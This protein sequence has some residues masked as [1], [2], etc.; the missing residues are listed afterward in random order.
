MS[1]AGKS[2]I[3]QFDST[4]AGHID[5]ENVGYASERPLGREVGIH[6]FR[7]REQGMDGGPPPA[8]TVEG[9]A[10][11]PLVLNVGVIAPGTGFPA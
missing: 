10:L 11:R 8:M 5:L 6:A 3:T 4:Y 1:E 9:Q 7:P 2:M